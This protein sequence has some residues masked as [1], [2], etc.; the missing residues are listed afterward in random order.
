MVIRVKNEIDARLGD[1]LT[2]WLEVEYSIFSITYWTSI[3]IDYIDCIN[4]TIF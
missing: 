1:S 3:V 4:Y 2:Y